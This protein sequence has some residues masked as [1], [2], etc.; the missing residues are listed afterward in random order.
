MY[1]NFTN[2]AK[3]ALAFGK[4]EAKRLNHTYFGSEHILIGILSVEDSIAAK[5]LKTNGVSVE[6]IIELISYSIHSD[7][8][9]TA[10]GNNRDTSPRAIKII[11]NAIEEARYFGDE[12]AGTEHLL[13]S[14]IKEFDCIATRLLN[15]LAANLNKMFGELLDAMGLNHIQIQSEFHKLSRLSNSPRS[16]SSGSTPFLNKYSADLTAMAREGRLD[17]VIGR[18]VEINKIITILNRRSKNNACLIGL[19]GVGKTAIVEGIANAILKNEVPELMQNKRLLSLDISGVVAGTKF[20]GEFEERMKN[21]IKEATECKD[22]IIFIDEL[23][24]MIGAGG[25]EGSIDASSML[26]P[27]MARGELQIIGAT[28]IEEYRKHIEKDSALERRFQPVHIDE[29]TEAESI[30][31]LNGIKAKYEEFHN[32]FLSDEAI[33]AAVDLSVRYINDRTLPDKA[34]D[35]IDEALARVKLRRLDYPESITDLEAQIRELKLEVD[36]LLS[37]EHISELMELQVKIEAMESDLD[38]KRKAFIKKNRGSMIVGK[39]DIARIVSEW[40][41]VPVEELQKDEMIRLKGLEKELHKRVIAQDEA[42]T[43]VSKAIKRGRTGF[44][45]PKRPIGSFL[46]LGPTGVGKTELTKALAEAVYGTE[47]ALIRIDM[48]EYMEKHSVSKMIGSPPGYVG[49]D[50]GGQLSDKIKRNPYSL[51]LLDEIEKAHPDVF[52]ILLQVLDEGH[53]TDS[54]GKKVSFKNTIIIMTSNVGAKNIVAPKN[55]GFIHD[56]NEKKQ[57]NTMKSKVLDEVKRLF[58]P[59]MLNRID[60]VIVFHELGKDHLSDITELLLNQLKNRLVKQMDIKLKFNSKVRDFILSKGYDKAYGARQLKRT[61][62][63]EIE[64][65]LADALLDSRIKHGDTVDLDVKDNEIVFNKDKNTKSTVKRR[66][67][68]ANGKGTNKNRK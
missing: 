66:I 12:K 44:K 49:H 21:I 39:P 35:L 5:I 8:I 24:R 55:L 23:H 27:A 68:N 58:K 25:A 6:K 20:R 2:A 9:I 4:R 37:S 29:P 40:S 26:K 10:E 16:G 51:L 47:D 50:D 61:I 41:K 43:A 1:K 59:E 46:F 17:P 13:I 33:K 36:E 22:V 32:A 38:K 30:E 56:D 63:S 15:S 64:N 11:N 60:E 7:E 62:Q 31:I 65:R 52:N 34:I 57:Y 18:S 54:H 67:S 19:P 28:T 48:S 42:V 53:I 14:I 3:N 45:D